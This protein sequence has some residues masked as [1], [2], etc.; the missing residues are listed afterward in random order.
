MV[1]LDISLL[2]SRTV[3]VILQSAGPNERAGYSAGYDLFGS[4]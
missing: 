3:S 4:S 2:L 1:Y